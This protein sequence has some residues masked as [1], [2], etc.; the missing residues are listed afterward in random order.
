LA[1]RRNPNLRALNFDIIAPALPERSIL[2]LD[3][4]VETVYGHQQG[5]AVG[6][7]SHRRGCKS[8]HS[9]L[10]FEGKS[11]LLVNAKL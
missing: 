11:R 6:V 8:Y 10:V 3:S 5:A 1:S 7:N 4:S 2:D 9:L